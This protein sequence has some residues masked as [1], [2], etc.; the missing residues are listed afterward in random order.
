METIHRGV[1]YTIT[2]NE[3]KFYISWA[4]GPFDERVTLEI[5]KENMEKALRSNED[6]GEVMRFA[7]TGFW[8]SKKSDDDLARD[9]IL[10]YAEL[11]IR[12]P[13]N[14]DLFSE[15]EVK[16]LLSKLDKE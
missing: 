16:E 8:P 14:R 4:V 6:A 11:L 5:S 2:E 3:G 7:E 15:E 13:D 9:F 10:K 1:G 12:I